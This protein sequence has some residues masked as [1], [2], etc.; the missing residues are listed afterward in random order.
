LRRTGW[1]SP[2]GRQVFAARAQ[3]GSTAASI[4][5]RTKVDASGLV[6]TIR[7]TIQQVDPEQPAA[8]VFPL[9]SELAR[10]AAPRRDNAILLGAFA[11]VAL[12]L[13]AVGLAGVIAYL[14]AHRTHEIGVRVAL[15]AERGDVLRLVVG[16]GA[17]R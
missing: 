3:A 13:A 16:E 9:E 6:E 11:G 12:V 17:R 1:G 7:R 8:R 2:G 4:A 14:V 5:I 15:G 10:S